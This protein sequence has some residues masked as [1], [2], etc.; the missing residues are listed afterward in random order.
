MAQDG[1]LRNAVCALFAL[2]LYF[3]GLCAA[4]VGAAGLNVVAAARRPVP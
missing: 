2:H 4:T 3:F 1:G